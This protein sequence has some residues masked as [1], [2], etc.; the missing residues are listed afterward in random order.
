[1]SKDVLFANLKALKRSA[2][3]LPEKARALRG[4]AEQKAARPGAS[5]IGETRAFA[6]QPYR[7]GQT[8]FPV[9]IV[10]PDDGHYMATFFDV[11]PFSPSGRYLAVTRVPFLHRI[12]VPG[13]AAQVVVMDLVESRATA[14]YE[15]RG[16]GAQLGANVQWGADDDTLFC[17]DVVDGRGT[18]VRIDR[19]TLAAQ[20]LQGPV[21]A[22]SPDRRYSY[23]PNIQLVNALIPGY[24]IPDP[25]FG[26]PRQQEERSASEGIWRTD[27]VTG[28]SALLVS[29]ADLVPQLT[30]QD[31]L[32]G[33]T[34][35]AF[36]VKVNRQGTRL[37]AVLFCRGARGRA[38]TPTQ[39][40]TMDMDGGNPRVAMPD[41][42]WRRGGHHPNWLPDGEHILMNLRPDGKAMAFVR[43]RHDGA[44]LDTVAP[45]HKGSGHPSVNPSGTHLLT[46][47]YKSDGFM[48]A[49]GEVPLRLIDLRS[50]TEAEL[51]CIFTNRLDGPRRVD[52]HPVWSADG[53]RIAFN[54]VIDGRRQVLVADMR[55]L[56]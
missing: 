16:W 39:L 29:F 40:V 8:L 7:P 34:Y 26:A 48:D 17:N 3:A 13:D 5:G 43:F 41:R 19:R 15:T 38:G 24:G 10:T 21:F 23:A 14:V 20:T 11:D 46:D 55:G 35:Y 33:G 47:C 56:A 18:G 32:A 9:S 22:L 45:G 42:L 6:P 51:C 52:P 54:G 2:K 36:N 31:G 4:Y 30:E 44:E 25:P 49:D 50:N 27:L 12:P 53:K 1:M 37:F 28:E